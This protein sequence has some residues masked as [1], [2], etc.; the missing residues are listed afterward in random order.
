MCVCVCV[1]VIVCIWRPYD[2]SYSVW[3]V[4]FS[5]SKTHACIG[6]EEISSL[7]DSN[8]VTYDIENVWRKQKQ[9]SCLQQKLNFW[10]K[11]FHIFWLSVWGSSAQ[12]HRNDSATFPLPS[13]SYTRSRHNLC[14]WLWYAELVASRAKLCKR[15]EQRKRNTYVEYLLRLKKAAQ[16]VEQTA[17]TSKFED[18][19]APCKWLNACKCV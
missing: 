7:V 15:T 8:N 2:I 10:S 11:I 6:L 18:Y 4:P 19:F 1:N 17:I 5:L 3:Y 14:V 12:A 9:F 13:L 16:N